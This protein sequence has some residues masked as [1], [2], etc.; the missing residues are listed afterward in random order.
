[1]HWDP[2]RTFDFVAR[3]GSL[4]AAAKAL[5]VSQ[6]TVSR[7]LQKL[8]EQAGS[9]LLYRESPIRLTD[10]GEA[11]L[12]AVTPMVEA[13]TIVKSVLEDPS[14]PEGEVILTTVGE[15]LRWMLS[16]HLAR[17]ARAYPKIHLRFLITNQI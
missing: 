1:M 17:F 9:P 8:E 13:A 3:F 5:G 2:L 7:H 6:S 11:L 12:E 14:G 4:T 15:I 10:R 16:K